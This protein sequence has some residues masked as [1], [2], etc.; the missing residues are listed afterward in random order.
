VL[1]LFVSQRLLFTE[2]GTEAAAFQLRYLRSLSQQRSA[3]VLRLAL[4]LLL[5]LLRCSRW[6]AV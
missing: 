2:R 3:Q 6:A 5:P 4:L 1:Q